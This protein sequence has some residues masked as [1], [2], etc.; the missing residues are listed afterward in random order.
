[1][2][3]YGPPIKMIFHVVEDFQQH[4][5]RQ[6]NEMNDEQM[7]REPFVVRAFVGMF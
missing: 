6:L 5:N 2:R 7:Q 1:M 3:F 4:L